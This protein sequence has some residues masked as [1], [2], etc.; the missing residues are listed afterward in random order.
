ML[1][2]ELDVGLRLV[3]MGETRSSRG[4][5]QYGRSALDGGK[6][7]ERQASL[8]ALKRFDEESSRSFLRVVRA[9]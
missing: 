2:I 5:A 3:D 4:A 7:C 9:R 8:A 1:R 6:T